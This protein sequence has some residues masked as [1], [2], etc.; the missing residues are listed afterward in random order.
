[1]FP[2]A[3]EYSAADLVGP[4]LTYYI[5]NSHWSLQRSSALSTFY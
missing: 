1:M 2:V 4:L 5:P 3:L